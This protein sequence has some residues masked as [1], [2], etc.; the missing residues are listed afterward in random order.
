MPYTKIAACLSKESYKCAF[1]LWGI[2]AV[3]SFSLF[4]LPLYYIYHN[5]LVDSPGPYFWLLFFRNWSILMALCLVACMLSFKFTAKMY[6]SYWSPFGI[7]LGAFFSAELFMCMTFVP[8]F[9]ITQ[10]FAIFP[11]YIIIIV[12]L[13][14]TTIGTWLSKLEILRSLLRQRAEAME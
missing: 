7:K 2:I 5:S 9:L 3:C 8:Y 4:Q 14:S 13:L 6:Q 10:R 1:K 12:L 11:Y